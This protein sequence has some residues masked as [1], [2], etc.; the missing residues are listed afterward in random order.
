LIFSSLNIFRFTIARQVNNS[1]QEEHYVCLAVSLS[2][3][4]KALMVS[5]QECKETFS[6][7]NWKF[8]FSING[9]KEGTEEELLL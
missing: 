9:K 3:R 4:D 8:K 7:L 5:T 2:A 1:G 6:L